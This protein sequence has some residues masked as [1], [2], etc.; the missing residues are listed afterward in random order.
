M[1]N[2]VKAQNSMVINK[3][4]WLCSLGFKNHE[5]TCRTCFLY[6]K[7]SSCTICSQDFALYEGLV[8]FDVLLSHSLA[9]FVA[10]F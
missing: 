9:T 5:P 1:G 4:C 6:E 7:T 10:I 2:I 3:K 8:A